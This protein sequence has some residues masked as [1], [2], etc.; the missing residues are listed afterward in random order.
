MIFSNGGGRYPKKTKKNKN[1]K[2][3]TNKKK[4]SIVRKQFN[5]LFFQSM[6]DYLK[7]ISNNKYQF[8]VH[9]SGG[10]GDCLFHSISEGIEIA[11]SI[12]KFKENRKLSAKG[13]RKIVSDSIL[14]WDQN[15]F[16]EYIEIAR[17][18]KMYGEWTDK[19]DPNRVHNKEL[20]SKIF[21]I[22]GSIHLGTEFDISILEEKLNIGIIVFQANSNFAKIYCIPSE[23]K[24]KRK[25]YILIYNNGG[26]YQ[27][28]GIKKN[29]NT[30]Y[31]G[32]LLLKD[33]PDFLKQEYKKVCNSELI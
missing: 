23:N 11:N 21:S 10:G 28:G 14:E 12:S 3:K 26:H 18:S 33:M 15:K 20:L 17:I 32:V 24:I 30:Y 6:K 31:K 7:K 9:E 4:D 16:N 22:M 5:H 25:Y 2:R 8:A 29:K 1:K 19:W 27:L 13:L